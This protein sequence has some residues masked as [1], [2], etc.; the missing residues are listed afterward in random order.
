MAGYAPEHDIGG[1]ADPFL[2]VKVR[3]RGDRRGGRLMHHLTLMIE[4][5]DE[6]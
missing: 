3:M 2:Q 4:L 1:I 5:T 6:V